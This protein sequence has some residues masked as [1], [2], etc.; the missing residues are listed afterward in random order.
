MQEIIVYTAIIGNRDYLLIPNWRPDNVRYVCFTDR[1]DLRDHGI[2]EIVKVEQELKDPVLD[3]KK[4]KMFPWKYLPE[5]DVS[6]WLDANFQVNNGFDIPIREMQGRDIYFFKHYERDCLYDEAKA[7]IKYKKGVANRIRKQVTA[8][9]KDGMPKH[10]G[11]PECN[12]ILRKDSPELR[13]L[14]EMWYNEVLTHSNRDQISLPYCVWKT[15]HDVIMSNYDARNG[16]YTVAFQ[17]IAKE[18]KPILLLLSPIWNPEGTWAV[19]LPDFLQVL[20]QKYQVMR[21]VT[22]SAYL[23]KACNE[24]LGGMG[25]QFPNFK[26]FQLPTDVTASLYDKILW[27]E[28]DMTLNALDDALKLLD[29]LDEPGVDIVSATYVQ[30]DGKYTFADHAP[31]NQDFGVKVEGA[32][33]GDELRD[34][35]HIP[36]GLTAVN[37][38]VYEKLTWPFFEPTFVKD[39]EGRLGFMGHDVAISEKLLKAGVKL[40]V[41]TTVKC[42]HIKKQT[43]WPPEP[44]KVKDDTDGTETEV[45]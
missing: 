13:E 45:S 26:P 34:V 10:F 33:E 2:W 9:R 7:C 35:R 4:Y 21:R 8:Y 37:Y 22:D 16:F 18:E 32:L 43:F 28:N 5:H 23:F 29:R 20:S 3:A 24:L 27:F 42:G 6:V 17:H 30:P 38:G 31:N 39:I 19:N 25:Q 41:D 12:T 11:L 36:L 44:E 14:M 1:E 15:D 40:W